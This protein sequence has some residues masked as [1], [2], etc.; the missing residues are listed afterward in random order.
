VREINVDGE[1]FEV[2]LQPGSSYVYEL[3]WV[4]GPNEGYGFACAAYGE[5]P[6]ADHAIEDA[7]RDFLGQV[8]P[9]TGYIG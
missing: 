1:R 6:L 2:G 9:T 4:S 7:I 3:K 8:D 5:G